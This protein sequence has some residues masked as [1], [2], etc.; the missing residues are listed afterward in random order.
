MESTANGT[1]T[2]SAITSCRIFSCPRFIVV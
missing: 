1:N 2:E